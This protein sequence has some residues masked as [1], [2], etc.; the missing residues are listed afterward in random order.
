VL[1]EN[2]LERSDHGHLGQLL[3]YAAGLGPATIIWIAPSFCDEHRA[4]LQWL[5]SITDERF[6]FFGIQLELWSISGSM[7]APR[8]SVAV[9]PNDWNRAVKKAT[10]QVTK[11]QS[12]GAA[13]RLEYW[14]VFLGSLKLENDRVRIPAANTLGNLRFDL[15]G[16]ELWITVYNA[17][18]LGSVGV[19]VKGSVAFGQLLLEDKE[20]VQGEL[21]GHVAWEERD[22]WSIGVS[23]RADPSMRDDWPRQ[24]EWLAAHL[25]TFLRVFQPYAE[26]AL[27]V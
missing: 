5:N 14:Q 8:F 13:R 17:T 23:L 15:K 10:M 9:A 25:K 21:G 18:S 24:H 4:A 1:I 6:K 20:R 12:E 16:R 27:P 11:A 19:F 26:A 3:T 22:P 7:P 2:Q